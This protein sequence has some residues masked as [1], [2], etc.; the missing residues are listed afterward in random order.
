MLSTARSIAGLR[1]AP[2][3]SSKEVS[4]KSKIYTVLEGISSCTVSSLLEGAASVVVGKLVGVS[5][6][7]FDSLEAFKLAEY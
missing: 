3:G 6:N 2:T 1:L 7:V 4:P 5:V